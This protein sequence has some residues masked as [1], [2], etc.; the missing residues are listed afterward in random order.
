LIVAHLSELRLG[1]RLF[2]REERGTNLRERD[3]VRVFQA[4]VHEVV[5][6]EP[7]LVLL[8]G[9]LFDTPQPSSGALAALRTGLDTL[10][11]GV[12]Q[13]PVLLVAGARDTP[14]RPAEP[15]VLAAFE[16][17]PG[18]SVASVA[19]R[20]VKVEALGIHALLLPHRSIAQSPAPRVE[21]D[22]D[23]R[24]NVLAAC[25]EPSREGGAPVD[26]GDWDYIALG[27][28]AS[29]Q[30]LGPRVFH[31][32]ALERVGTEPWAEDSGQA[33]GFLSFD[34]E[35]GSY[36]F[37]PLPGRAVA[38]LT[39]TFSGSAPAADLEERVLQGLEGLPAGPDGKL[40]RLSFRDAGNGGFGLPLT[41]DF[42]ARIRGRAA[43]L[44][45]EPMD[46][47]ESDLPRGGGG[48]APNPVV[49]ALHRRREGGRGD[50]SVDLPGGLSALVARDPPVRVRLLESF[51]SW[52][53]CNGDVPGGDSTSGSFRIHTVEGAGTGVEVLGGGVSVR[54]PS[55]QWIDSEADP[56]RLLT[57]LCRGLR[58]SA[59]EGTVEG[60]EGRADASLE[61]R[62]EPRASTEDLRVEAMEVEG[63][64]DVLTM[65][66]LRERQDAETHLRTYRDRARDL[67][68]RLRSLRAQGET[69]PCPTCGV[70]LGDRHGEVLGTLEE[71][72][73]RV[74]QDGTWWRRRREQLE[75]KPERLRAME[76]RALKLQAAMRR[77][78][79]S[80][81]GEGKGRGDQ[82]AGSV[83]EKRVEEERDLL[84]RAGLLF[85]RLTAGRFQGLALEGGELLPQ[86]GPSGRPI[87]DREDRDVLVIALHLAF[88][89]LLISSD[90]GSSRVLV[91]AQ[92][93]DRLPDE[94]IQ[95]ILDLLRTRY[96]SGGQYLVLTAGR[97]A[98]G[99]PASFDGVVEVLPEPGPGRAAFRRLPAGRARVVLRDASEH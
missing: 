53:L 51:R 45:V 60:E 47:W 31:P 14:L 32:G 36:R 9:D 82:V 81:R 13:A 39:F 95:R 18:V 67:R 75:W 63:E 25:G 77:V 99:F 8:T 21:P 97:V 23:F 61:G 80:D 40:L 41:P 74:V 70:V 72:W 42:L 30:R 94:P 52:A 76:T 19:A 4:A 59:P 29:F 91:F 62:P 6:L 20:S 1:M 79:G 49:S 66:W 88:H 35:D 44:Q 55:V 85:V 93:L 65:D 5:R 27:C 50:T 43:H 34:L 83:E 96:R 11:R 16:S 26:V 90:N 68:K 86:G 84:R 58:R 69:L 12:P 71:E 33:R 7:Q 54:T 89:E 78:A 10:R 28:G 37:H 92:A 15:G 38:S 56:G 57:E 3:L 98:E 73:E 17:L 46:L 48:E 2:S 24:W 22:L 87:L 64:V